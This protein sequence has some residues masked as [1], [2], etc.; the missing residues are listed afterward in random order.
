M[1]YRKLTGSLSFEGKGLHSGVFCR[2]VIEP[3]DGGLTLSAGGGP[4]LPL[5]GLG[6]EGGGRGSDLIFPDG[7]RVRTCEHLLSAL[8][9]AGVWSAQI[10]VTGPEMPA[11]DG[12][13]LAVG[14]RVMETSVPC[15]EGPEPFRIQS[16]V[17]AGDLSRFVVAM[18]S[19][20]FHVTCVVDYE[21]KA[22]GTQILD[23]EGTPEDYLK[24]IAPAR[25]FALEEDLD[26]LRKAGMALG[27]SLDNAILV[28]KTGIEASGG[29][30]FSDEFVRH[31]TL[32]LI[33][34]LAS[35]GR[36]VAAHVV[37]VRAGHVLHLQLA[38]RLRALFTRGGGHIS[39]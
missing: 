30:R 16:P 7:K 35:L 39:D 23:W 5:S 24:M 32:D 13:A 9:G 20:S 14:Q 18:P 1:N 22:I 15:D 38:E 37:A 31:K 36:P 8:T 26:A 12:C 27:G 4:A 33:G 28:K 19:P 17:C 6:L 34:D 10:S 29:L 3:S 2:V 25:T 11:F 21:A